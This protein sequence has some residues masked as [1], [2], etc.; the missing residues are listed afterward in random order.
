MLLGRVPDGCERQL[1]QKL[2]FF[3]FFFQKL[4]F[5]KKTIVKSFQ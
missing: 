3:F 1:I 2:V 4:V 5:N